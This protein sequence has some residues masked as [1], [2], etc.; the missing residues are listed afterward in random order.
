MDMIQPNWI[1][2]ATGDLSINGTHL[3]AQGTSGSVVTGELTL[4]LPPNAV[5]KR[6]AFIDTDSNDVDATLNISLHVLQVYRANL[7]IIEP[8][9]EVVGEPLSLNVSEPHR[10]LLFLENPGNGL[11]TFQLAASATS[12]DPS[13]TPDVSF[14]YF[15][16][17]KTLGALATGIGTVD[18][19]LS[20][21]TPAVTPFDIT[22]TWT[23]LGGDAVDSTTVAVKTS[24]RLAPRERRIAISRRRSLIAL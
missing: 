5:P 14:T 2:T 6:H 7:N 3:V 13:F 23:S 4:Q 15:D 18:I 9:S 19:T 21:E 1:W 12:A 22:F 24:V 20:E 17:Q 10:F 8:V 11:D 16:P